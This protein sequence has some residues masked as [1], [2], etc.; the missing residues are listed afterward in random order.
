MRNLILSVIKKMGYKIDRTHD[1]EEKAISLYRK[2]NDFTMVPEA[3]FVDNLKLIYKFQDLNG[4]LV[5]CGVWRGGMSAAIS[6]T[7]PNRKTYLFDSFEGLPDAQDIDG[8]AAKDW[9]QNINSPHFYD[10]CKAEMEFAKTAMNKSKSNYSLVKGWFKDT[11]PNFDFNEPI[12]VL[13]LDGDWYEST[14]DCLIHLFPKV[15]DGGLIILDDYYT[16]DGCS[17]ATHDF[18]SKNSSKSRLHE[19]NMGVAYIIKRD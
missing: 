14:M 10:N 19:T 13:R 4:C 9:Q 3:I 7:L 15:V 8:E 1:Y 18:L 17:R 6:E 11:L 12:A 16:W 5:E 2:Y